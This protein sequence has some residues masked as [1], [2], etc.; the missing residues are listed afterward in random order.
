MAIDKLSIDFDSVYTNIYMLGGG[1]V[2]SEP[3]VAAVSTDDKVEVKAI[4]DEARKLIGKTA[5][6]T[7]IVF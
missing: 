7:K 3:T 2:L 4:G 1:I 5:K 6:N